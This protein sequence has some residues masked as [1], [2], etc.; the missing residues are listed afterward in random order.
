MRQTKVLILNVL[1]FSLKIVNLDALLI[2][3]LVQFSVLLG[4]FTDVFLFL[5]HLIL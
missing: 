2:H 4:E 3:D 5:L 1:E